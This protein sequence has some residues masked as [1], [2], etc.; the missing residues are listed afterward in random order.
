MGLEHRPGRLDRQQHVCGIPGWRAVLRHPGRP[1]RPQ[2]DHDVGAAAVLRGH[3]HQCLRQ[4][5]P[6]VLYPA[7][8]RRHRHGR[9]RRHHRALPG[10]VRQ[11]QIPWPFHGCAGRVL[12][13][14]LC[15]VGLAG[16]LH[17]AAERRRLALDHDHRLGA[18][19]LP[20]VVAQVAVRIAALAGT[21]RPDRRSQP[22]LH[23]DRNRS[24]AE[25]GPSVAHAGRNAQGRG[26]AGRA[27]GRDGQAGLAVLEAIPGHHRAGVGL[28]D[29]RAV[30]LLRLPGVDSQPAGRTR[31][32]HH[33]ELLVHHPDLP[34]ADSGLL[35]G[36][37]LQ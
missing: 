16:L 5:L 15:D 32:H 13:L 25:P 7:H 4:E 12:F 3:L 28:L 6:R 18:G 11:Q 17:R 24:A 19:R 35:L 23:V 31:L 20:A 1:L 26:G 14:R 29:H 34:G 33:E 37:V 9:G 30:L 2:E 36:R 10:G 8:D 27:R 22:Y 21:F